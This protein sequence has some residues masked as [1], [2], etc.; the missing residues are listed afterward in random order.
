MSKR[1]GKTSKPRRK[2][3][4]RAEPAGE[5]ADVVDGIPGRSAGPAG[6]GLLWIVLI[7]A[8]WVAFMIYCQVGG[9]P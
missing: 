1:T 9:T 8:A 7:F 2:A 5:P 4:P 6:R 3:A